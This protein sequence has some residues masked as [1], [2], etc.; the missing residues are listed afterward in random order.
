MAWTESFF[1]KFDFHQSVVL[2]FFSKWLTSFFLFFLSGVWIGEVLK[3]LLFK[4]RF[5]PKNTLLLQYQFAVQSDLIGL[6][7]NHFD[8]SVY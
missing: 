1:E 7:T 8:W 6:F 5:K 4:V 3:P 2:N